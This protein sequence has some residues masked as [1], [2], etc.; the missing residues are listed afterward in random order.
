M[1]TLFPNT[2][3]CLFLVNVL[4]EDC[5]FMETCHVSVI[6]VSTSDVDVT[7]HHNTAV[8]LATV[9]AHVC[10]PGFRRDI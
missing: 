6:P 9:C 10:V 5:M 3:W 1:S 7:M 8:K 4:N 2:W